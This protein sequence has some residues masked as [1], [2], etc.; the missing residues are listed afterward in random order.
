MMYQREP[1]LHF[2]I[3]SFHG[4]KMVK[5]QFPEVLQ[6]QHPEFP[7]YVSYQF[8]PFASFPPGRI[9]IIRSTS[10]KTLVLFYR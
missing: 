5:L 6:F 2:K 4:S 8:L 1:H 7:V 10:N 3:M 9:S